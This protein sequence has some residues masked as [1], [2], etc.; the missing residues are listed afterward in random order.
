V[1]GLR[2]GRIVNS[3]LKR[4]GALSLGDELDASRKHDSVEPIRSRTQSDRALS[5]WARV[6]AA[7]SVRRLTA[8]VEADALARA[9]GSAKRAYAWEREMPIASATWIPFRPSSSS[10]ATAARR[11]TRPSGIARSSS[12][13]SAAGPAAT[14]S[15]R[16]Q[17]TGARRWCEG[18]P[19]RQ[20][21]S[22]RATGPA[23]PRCST[24]S[25]SGAPPSRRP[26][27]GQPPEGTRP[28]SSALRSRSRGTGV[29]QPRDAL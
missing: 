5:L 28:T 26:G 3:D 2:G 25:A 19:T 15:H 18:N 13:R 21:A 6:E 9:L 22:V 24:T 8:A 27:R 4:V 17:T 1:D 29:A 10:A 14:A 23:S 20:R 16:P 12:R 7:Y 11:S